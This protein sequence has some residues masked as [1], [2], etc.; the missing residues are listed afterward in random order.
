MH[1]LD[2]AFWLQ[3]SPV[4]G[5]VALT[6]DEFDLGIEL[7]IDLGRGNGIGVTGLVAEESEILLDLSAG[8]GVSA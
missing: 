8:A 4:T 5:G 1:D 7:G 2:A 6:R 3:S